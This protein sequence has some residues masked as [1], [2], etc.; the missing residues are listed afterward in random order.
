M[1]SAQIEKLCDEDKQLGFAMLLFTHAGFKNALGTQKR[2]QF[3]LEKKLNALSVEQKVFLSF[4]LELKEKTLPYIYSIF[5]QENFFMSLAT[6]IKDF[7]DI[8]T[9]IY[10][11]KGL[12]GDFPKT[13]FFQETFAYTV[14]ALIALP[15]YLFSFQWYR[16][17]TYLPLHTPQLDSVSLF[18]SNILENPN[19]HLFSFTSLPK[20]ATDQFFAALI[21]SFFFSL[22]LSLPHFV[23]LRRL[24]SQGPAAAA[25]SVLGF[26]LANFLLLVGVVYGLRFLIIPYLSLEPLH[27][28][29]G[30][31]IIAFFIKDCSKQKGFQLVPLWNTR[32]LAKIGAYTFALTWCEEASIF[33][34]FNH[35]TLNAQNTCFDIYP[36]SNAFNS[37]VVHTTYLFAFFVGHCVFSG[38][39]YGLIFLGSRYIASSRWFTTRMV[40]LRL[41]RL[42]LFLVV[43]FTVSSFPYYGLDYLFTQAAGF[44]P[45]DPVYNNTF[46]SPTA[47]H[48][49]YPHFFK[50]MPPAQRDTK[51]AVNLDL[52]YFDRGLYF[53]APKQNKNTAS[54]T[55]VP[56]YSF[57]ELNY[58]GEYAWIM[59]N[60]LSKDL[61]KM[62][63]SVF[64]P[65][66]QKPR[67]R[68]LQL[69]KLNDNRLEQAA[70]RAHNT[71]TVGKL[72]Q[73]KE[74]V[75]PGERT[76]LFLKMTD[77][78]GRAF[79][80]PKEVESELH[81]FD[82]SSDASFKGNASDNKQSIKD[83]ASSR[84]NFSE[85]SNSYDNENALESV[86]TGRSSSSGTLQEKN[87]H[88][89]IRNKQTAVPKKIIENPRFSRKKNQDP[90]QEEL[91]FEGKL[92]QTYSK[93]FVPPFSLP[94]E[95]MRLRDLPI[96]N[97]IK[98][99]YF[100]NSVYRS[101]LEIDIDRFLARQPASYR[102]A[103]NQEFQL[104]A[105]RQ[106]LHKYYNWLRFYQPFEKM[107]A[108]R[109]RIPDSKSF[110]DRVYHQQFKG[111]LK[112]ARRLFKITFDTEE[113]PSKS[114]VMSY[115][116]MLYKNLQEKENPFAHE[117]LSESKN[118]T[119]DRKIEVKSH[120]SSQKDA[121][122]EHTFE[123]CLSCYPFI[124]ESNASPTYAGWDPLSRRFVISNRFVFQTVE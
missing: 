50:E 48:T 110:V 52:N 123:G 120:Q 21:N 61:S 85:D 83:A 65:M 92:D 23:S 75:L 63:P 103:E 8:L 115:D 121:S 96:K 109:F 15:V 43:A 9:E 95:R 78:L 53:N 82:V 91:V 28:I 19:S 5:L 55:P 46:L 47:I 34:S 57:E 117:E 122:P 41:S 62:R 79:L 10:A 89:P 86:E 70:R 98:K 49:K 18:Q 26:I 94:Y 107:L 58:Q 7:G 88:S 76:P 33:H 102:L 90:I 27:Y 24:F 31:L 69:R 100:L 73:A 3:C 108:L 116:Q 84:L 12:T 54:S 42:M 51:T 118:N 45:E 20:Q 59:R 36:C 30:V 13:L 35:L 106:I 16:D 39:W 29:V 64:T 38:F 25:A 71:K 37:F 2:K 80:M 93:G 119:S 99:R 17:I 11:T 97:V 1:Y 72:S 112:I 68:Y 6:S 87:D 114:R 113:N 66:F 44:L 104:Y 111:T 56:A 32:A 60:Q 81:D 77:F 40:T 22:P 14:K 4:A 67:R 124:E 105:K 101:L 74:G